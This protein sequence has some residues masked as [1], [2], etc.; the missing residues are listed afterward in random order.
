MGLCGCARPITILL[1]TEKWADCIPLMQILCFAS[2]TAGITTI[3]LNL[4][5]V[6]GRSDL[7]LRLE[8]IKKAIA[9]SI[10]VATSFFGVKIMCY[11]LVL[12]SV[13]ALYLNTIFTKRILNY[14]LWPQL[15]TILPYFLVSLVILAESWGVCHFI[16]NDWLALGISVPL[17]ALSY[18]LLHM[19][20][21]TYAFTEAKSYLTGILKK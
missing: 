20:L 17:C 19:L 14:G 15:K 7:V 1:L 18:I 8:I 5:Y 6:K 12:Y 9:F 11:G 4:L 2:L 3:N 16:G 10:L 13:V 21:G